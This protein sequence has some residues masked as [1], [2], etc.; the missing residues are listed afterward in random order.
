MIFGCLLL[1]KTKGLKSISKVW[2]SDLSTQRF[3]VGRHR[4]PF[5][6]KSNV[7]ILSSFLWGRSGFWRQGW[8]VAV[9]DLVR[10]QKRELR[11]Y[12]Q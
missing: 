10:E 8:S 12:V 4:L 6:G 1:I 3:T 11:L 5:T 9:R 7:R 2:E